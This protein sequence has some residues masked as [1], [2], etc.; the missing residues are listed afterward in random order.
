MQNRKTSVLICLS[1]LDSADFIERATPHVP[2]DRPIVLLYVVDT[3]PAQDIGYIA[4]R[5]HGGMQGQAG[6]EALMEAADDD[7]G[8]AILQ[9]ATALCTRIGYSSQTITRQIRRGRPEQEIIATASQSDLGIGLVVIGSS[10][11]RGPHPLI[12][13]ASVGHVARF[14]VDHSPCDVLLLR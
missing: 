8:N 7:V 5:M 4:R 1:G 14:V 6:R 10:Y 3:R 12:G 2:L 11:K 13:P 9:E